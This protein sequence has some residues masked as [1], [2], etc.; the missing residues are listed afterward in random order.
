MGQEGVHEQVVRAEHG[1]DRFQ[2]SGVTVLA[3]PVL[4]HWF[5]SAAVRAIAEQLE[6]GPTFPLHLEAAVAE[7]EL[8]VSPWREQF[9]MA[10]VGQLCGGLERGEEPFAVAVPQGEDD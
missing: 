3:T 7:E 10:I 4:C 5:E 9:R 1:A 8:A 6:P 2:N